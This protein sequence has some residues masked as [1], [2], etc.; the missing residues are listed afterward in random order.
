MQEPHFLMQSITK[1]ED[2]FKN[3]QYLK[4]KF[5]FF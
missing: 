5:H 3:H 2:K 1:D 4:Y